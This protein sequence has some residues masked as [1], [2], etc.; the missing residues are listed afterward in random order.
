[1]GKI[2]LHVILAS[3]RMMPENF[4]FPKQYISNFYQFYLFLMDNYTGNKIKFKNI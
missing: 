4:V 1:M 3:A 2:H